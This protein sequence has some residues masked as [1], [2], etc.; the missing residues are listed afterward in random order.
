MKCKVLIAVVCVLIG[1][2]GGFFVNSLF[3]GKSVLYTEMPKEILERKE[4]LDQDTDEDEKLTQQGSISRIDY[5]LIDIY[6][7]K[8]KKYKVTITKYMESETYKEYVDT[9][10][11]FQFNK[12]KF[13]ILT[14]PSGRGTTPEYILRVHEGDNCIK[15]IECSKI[16]AGILDDKW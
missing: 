8:D 15:T 6:F 4:Q 9:G 7:E 14:I 5:P 10:D 13:S 16:R 3:C 1:G 12:E 11:F 2:I